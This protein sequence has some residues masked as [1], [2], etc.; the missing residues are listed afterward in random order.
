MVSR[1]P[2]LALYGLFLLVCCLVTL[3]SKAAGLLWL[4]WVLAGLAMGWT[5]RRMAAVHDA[6]VAGQAAGVWLAVTALALALRSVGMLYWGDT[7]DERHA[8]LRLVLMA[9]AVWLVLRRP[10]AA[11]R[12][13]LARCL[14]LLTHGFAVACVLGLVQVARVG[15]EHLTTHPIAWAVGGALLSIWLLHSAVW[16]ATS[17]MKRYFWLAGGICGVLAVLVS[18][19]R[20]A[21]GVVVWWL[22]LGVYVLWRNVRARP[23][24]KRWV[25]Q[26]LLF[27]V[28]A[29]GVGGLV[30]Q[31]GLWTRPALALEQAL[32]EYR[33]TQQQAAG[34]V[35]TSFGARLYMWQ[36]AAE[37]VVQAPVW[38]YGQDGRRA[39]VN[40]WGRDANSDVVKSLGHAH[41]QYLN[42]ALDHGLWG[43][44]SGLA[45]VLGLGWLAVYLWRR[46]YAFAGSTLAGAAFMHATASLSNVN[47]AH[48]YYSAVLSLVVGVAVVAVGKESCGHPSP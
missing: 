27:V 2:V 1:L 19:S 36:R 43:L 6:G 33:G 26:A 24:W 18:Q 29:A 48:N 34:V 45:Y 8:E 20:G 17:R 31:S 15:R 12:L 11:K 25:R 41:N 47:F 40:Q 9:L 28:V 30:W 46:Q 37:A 32:H 23:D 22:G 35:D 4:L 13:L 44:G 3:S 21:F 38:G 5:S 42:D 10:L 39:L 7:W 14:R 16:Q